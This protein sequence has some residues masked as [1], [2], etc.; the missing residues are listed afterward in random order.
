MMYKKAKHPSVAI[1]F[2]TWVCA[3]HI[4]DI[5]IINSPSIDEE[6]ALQLAMFKVQLQDL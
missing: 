4:H 3:I 1:I 6:T 5:I 2:P